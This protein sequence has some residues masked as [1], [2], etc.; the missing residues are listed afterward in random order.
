M[1]MAINLKR[2]LSATAISGVLGL[3]ALG[4]GT[5]TANADDGWG[6]WGPWVPWHPGQAI[7]NWVPWHPGE[8]VGNWV[9]GPWHGGDWEDWQGEND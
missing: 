6:P 8:F 4:L 3:T 1:M 9:P 2:A 7:D 5:G